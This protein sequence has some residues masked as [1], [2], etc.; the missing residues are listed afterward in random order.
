MA[1]KH[2]MNQSQTLIDYIHNEN[3]NYMETEKG[4]ELFIYFFT[5]HIPLLEVKKAKSNDIDEK[6]SVI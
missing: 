1:N 4:F 2:D 6:K 5:E 3:I